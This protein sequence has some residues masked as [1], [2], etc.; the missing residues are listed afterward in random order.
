MLTGYSHQVAK[1]M[2]TPTIVPSAIVE[3]PGIRRNASRAGRMP[4]QIKIRD[5]SAAAPVPSQM[6]TRPAKPIGTQNAAM[7]MA[8]MNHGTS[9]LRLT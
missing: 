7:H 4:N 6:L 9:A 2:A 1:D 8:K 5:V 3:A